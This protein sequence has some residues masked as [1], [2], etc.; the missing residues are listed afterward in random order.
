A[1]ALA[2][3]P[4]LRGLPGNDW[5]VDLSSWRRD[6]ASVAL[7]A[8]LGGVGE[9]GSH[10]G[11]ADDALRER[12]ALVHGRAADLALLTDPLLRAAFGDEAVS[13]RVR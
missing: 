6:A 12:D 1:A 2:S 10:P 9:I 7:L 11:Y 3:A 5:Y 4:F 8:A 13:W